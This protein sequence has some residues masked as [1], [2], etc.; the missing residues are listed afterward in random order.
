MKKKMGISTLIYDLD[1]ARTFYVSGKS[2]E[3]MG[4]G[5]RRVTRTKTLDGGA[6]VYDAGFSYSD[7]EW[8]VSMQAN[9]GDGVVAF[10]RRIVR[11]YNL[12]KITNDLGVYTAVPSAYEEGNGVITLKALIMS[13]LT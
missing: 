9:P 3:S 11:T 4:F 13:K 10:V 6:V 12:I 7:L 2:A 1:G 8:N 5:R